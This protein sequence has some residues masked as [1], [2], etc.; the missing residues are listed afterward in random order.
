MLIGADRILTS[1]N[2]KEKECGMRMSLWNIYI[3]YCMS[4]ISLS[5]RI[6][7]LV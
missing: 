7:F 6:K 1:Q 2:E 3:T 5:E 4:R